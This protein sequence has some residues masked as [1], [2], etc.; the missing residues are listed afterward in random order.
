MSG[1][2]SGQARLPRQYEEA[3]D[4]RMEEAL[5]DT[6]DRLERLDQRMLLMESFMRMQQMTLDKMNRDVAALLLE[7]NNNKGQTSDGGEDGE[8]SLEKSQPKSSL[9]AAENGRGHPTL[10]LKT[11]WKSFLSVTG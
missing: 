1:A 11:A 7:K 3:I 2:S 10:P 9:K 5:V 6:T 4:L 8:N